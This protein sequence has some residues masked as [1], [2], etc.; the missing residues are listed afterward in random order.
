MPPCQRLPTRARPQL[1]AK[2]PSLRLR[3]CGPLSAPK[4]ARADAQRAWDAGA[5]QFGFTCDHFAAFHAMDARSNVL[6]LG[7]SPASAV[8]RGGHVPAAGFA[9]RSDRAA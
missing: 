2:L 4:P 8:E 7:V 5:A 3:D 1:S 9:A 6:G